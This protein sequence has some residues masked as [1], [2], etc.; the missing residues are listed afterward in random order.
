MEKI[1][2]DYLNASPILPEV[3]EG[4]LPFLFEH[5]GNPQSLYT[6]GKETKK[7]ID[8]ARGEVASLIGADPTEI[9]FT[10][11]GSEANNWVI[12]GVCTAFEDKGRH[13][14]TSA[15]EHISISKPLKTWESR[16]GNLTHL[17]VDPFGRVDAENVL[18]HV[19]PHTLFMTLHH[20]QS[21][22][23]TVQSIKEIVDRIKESGVLTHSDGV[24]AVGLVPVDVKKLGVDYYTLS[25]QS[26]Y[27]PKGVGALYIKRGKRI[28]PLIE[29]GNQENGK[30]AGLENVAG[31][32]GFGIAARGAR[33]KMEERSAKLISLRE[34]LI[35]E[36]LK[37]IPEAHLTGDPIH[38]LPNHASFYIEGIEGEALILLM[39]GWGLAAA[40]GSSCLTGSISPR[41]AITALGISPLNSRGTLVLTLGWKTTLEEIRDSVLIIQKAIEELKKICP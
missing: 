11:S 4:M 36:I 31:I 18:R 16:G 29:G 9:Y 7:A 27:G 26:I 15:I 30:R 34:V 22:I 37:R 23:G 3:Y 14:I 19:Q 12:K 6:G 24:S 10:S 17:P 28:N 40:T 35:F 5:F 33:E 1:Y 25:A 13:I 38:R 8:L 21:E 32:V 41:S 39:S 2:L 20:A